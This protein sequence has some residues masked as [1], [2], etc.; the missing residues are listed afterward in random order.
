MFLIFGLNQ[1]SPVLFFFST[2]IV[3]VPKPHF[4]VPNFDQQSL[5]INI[6]QY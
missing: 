2:F 6:D 1:N 4:N 5:L 3:S